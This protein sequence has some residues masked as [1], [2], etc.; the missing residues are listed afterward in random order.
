MRVAFFSEV[1][2]P[3]IDGI[4]NRLSHTIRWLRSQ[5]HEV[6]VFGPEHSV[7]EHAGARVVRVPG[8]VF[9]P[10]PDLRIT[11]PD[12]RILWELWRFG[13]DVVHAVGPACLGMW[14]V[15]ASQAL[16]LPV[17]ASHHTDLARYAPLYG[18]GWLPIWRMLRAIH[19]G[20]VRNLA[21][22]RFTRKEM[23]DHGIDNVGIWRGGVDTELFHPSKRSP[24]M[25]Q[26]LS[27]GRPPDGPVLLY[28]GRVSA[29]KNLL[30]LREAL[31]AVPGSRLAIVG[32]GPARSELE[33][34]F[35]DFPVSFLGF[36]RGEELASAFASADVFV[37]PSTTETLGFVSL[38]AMS[39]GCPVV[40][41]RAGG[42]PDLVQDGVNGLLFDP[43]R[44]EQAFEAIR[45]LCASAPMRAHYAEQGRKWAVGCSWESETRKLLD[46]YRKAMAIHQ[47]YGTLGRLGKL[48]Y[49]LLP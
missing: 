8:M 26:R 24:E 32:D 34:E 7:P 1:F 11:A 41:A 49:A 27:G 38:E 16:G 14:G 23:L 21:P 37:M 17:V 40:A 35:A 25:R 5:G 31:T 22:S 36:L 46:E 9:Q 10:Y 6:L 15:A 13:P 29:E 2:L 4:T 44:P 39:S 45:Q 33:R 20:A 42:I 48:R 30:L 12:P 19:S 43:E 47:P 3:K 18:L 28:V